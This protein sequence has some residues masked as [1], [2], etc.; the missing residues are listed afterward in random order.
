MSHDEKP[1]FRLAM[2]VVDRL[3]RN[4]L[5]RPDQR[6]VIIQKVSQG[7]MKESDWDRE[8]DRAVSKENQP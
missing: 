6:N 7:Q 8:I 1:A 4:G 5:L 2:I 3:I